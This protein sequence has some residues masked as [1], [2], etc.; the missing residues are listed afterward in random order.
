M[1]ECFIFPFRSFSFKFM[2]DE[3]T[4]WESAKKFYINKNYATLYM[5]LTA[6]LNLIL[7]LSFLFGRIGRMFFLIKASTSGGFT[8]LHWI[9][10]MQICIASAKL[11][12]YWYFVSFCWN[13]MFIVIIIER[14]YMISFAYISCIIYS[15]FFAWKFNKPIVYFNSLNDVSIPHLIW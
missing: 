4:D 8:L 12:W 2:H 11:T 14:L 9:K 3:K 15:A 1:W 13:V 10:C 6:D 7:R 5:K